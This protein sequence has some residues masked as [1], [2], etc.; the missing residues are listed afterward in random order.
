M[1]Q[2]QG[3]C[4]R[5]G[6]EV[7]FELQYSEE[8]GEIVYIDC[9]CSEMICCIEYDEEQ[10]PKIWKDFFNSTYGTNV[11]HEEELLQAVP[12]ESPPPESED[13]DTGIDEDS[14]QESSED[15]IAE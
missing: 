6:S 1:E 13:T 4:A 12:Q 7:S 9:S 10:C 8:N 2:K 15:D 3:N 14:S 11:S 5:L